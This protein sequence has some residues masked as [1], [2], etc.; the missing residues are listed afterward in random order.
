MDTD[1]GIT[2]ATRIADGEAV[3]SLARRRL[4]S[5]IGDDPLLTVRLWT[6]MWEIDRIA[7]AAKDTNAI[8]DGSTLRGL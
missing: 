1:E 5:F 2:G 8:F 7:I 3:A 6:K 4:K